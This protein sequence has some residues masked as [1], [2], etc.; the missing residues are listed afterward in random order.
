M[1]CHL[2]ESVFEEEQS[3][4]YWLNLLA[5][6]S[7]FRK[8]TKMSEKLCLK[9]NDYQENTSN[10]FKSLKNDK[11]FSDVTLVCDDGRQTN[12]HKIILSNS[13]PFFKE[14]LSINKHPHSLIYMRG[15]KSEDLMAIVDFIYIGEANIFQE[16]LDSFLA[17]AEELKLKGLMGGSVL[18]NE[19]KEK[20]RLAHDVS[21]IDHKKEKFQTKNP[22]D[23]VESSTS[24]LE[25]E[26]RLLIPND[27]SGHFEELEEKIKSMMERS[28]RRIPSGREMAL[29]CKVCGKEGTNK[30]IK[31]HIEGQHIEGLVIPCDVCEKTF[32]SRNSLRMHMK[33][34]HTS[35]VKNNSFNSL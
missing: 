1:T 10:A 34:N 18:E 29:L 35:G 28:T 16:N 33:Q 2:S 6:L 24:P 5:T 30:N 23:L 19:A 3:R 27:F 9:W 21:R 32:R 20:S 22:L 4:D 7:L 25:N 15:L 31:D 8:K 26:R 14:I 11:E 17:L 13:S 12:V